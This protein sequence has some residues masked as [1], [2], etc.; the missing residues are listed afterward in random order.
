MFRDCLSL[1]EIQNSHAF[2]SAPDSK[3]T[4]PMRQFVFDLSQNDL[5]KLNRHVYLAAITGEDV[6]FCI[7]KNK[8]K[9]SSEMY[10]TYIM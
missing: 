3:P 8:V 6:Y 7:V 10:L 2:R 9:R 5:E 1:T 4:G